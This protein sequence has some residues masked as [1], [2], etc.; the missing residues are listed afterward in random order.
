MKCEVWMYK[1]KI[2]P[3]KNFIVDDIE[4][5]LD[6][7]YKRSIDDCFQYQKY[8]GCEKVIKI[9]ITE[10]NQEFLKDNSYNYLSMQN[11]SLEETND[12]DVQLTEYK[13]TY[14][15]ILKRVPL[16][17]KTIQLHLYMDTANTFKENY[18]YELTNK[19]K[20]HRQHRDRLVGRNLTTQNL[21]TVVGTVDE[22]G[23]Y[24]AEISLGGSV[25]RQLLNYNCM[26][27]GT[28]ESLP[29][30]LE[31]KYVAGDRKFYVKYE[32]Y[33]AGTIT[34]YTTYRYYLTYQRKIDLY[35]EGISPVLYKTQSS[36]LLEDINVS[37]N[38]I[39]RNANN[40]DPD[41]YNQV[42]PVNCFCMPDVAT[43][44]KMR[45][46]NVITTSSIERAWTWITNLQNPNSQWKI[47]YPDNS[48]QIINLPAQTLDFQTYYIKLTI[49]GGVLKITY[50]LY[51]DITPIPV[52]DVYL[53]NVSINQLELISGDSI[54]KIYQT[55]TNYD[56]C[57]NESNRT[58]SPTPT[59]K[60]LDPL[61]DLDR[62][63]AKLIKIIKLPYAPFE[64]SS[65]TGIPYEWS[66][67][68]VDVSMLKLANI[69]T[70]FNRVISSDLVNPGYQLRY[71]TDYSGIGNT[72]EDDYES[73]LF[74]SDYYR[75]KFVYDSFGF[76]FQLE[77][78]DYTNADA[79]EHYLKVGYAITTTINSRF[80][81][82]FP[83]YILTRSFTDFDNVLP[84]A[85]NNEVVLYTSQYINYLRTGY[86]YDVKAKQ[87]QAIGTTVGTL[88][89]GIG[90]IAVGV[91]TQQPYLVAMGVASFGASV[92]NAVNT[93]ANNEQQLYTK[94]AQLKQ[95]AIGVE[96]SDDVDIMEAY[97]D[98][99]AYLN[100][101]ECSDRLKYAL[102]DLFYYTGYTYEAIEKPDTYSRVYFNYVQA[103][104]D[105]KPLNNVMPKYARDDLIERYKLGI[106]R[107]HSVWEGQSHG[108]YWDLDQERENWE[109]SLGRCY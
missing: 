29:I 97:S 70:K 81:F 2:F 37:W 94:Q 79:I 107:I 96:G 54:V 40:I 109:L 57:P 58:L 52:E 78:V 67:Y 99:R 24:T 59:D 77:L 88:A 22:A 60:I 103:E 3:E 8:D 33:G 12:E 38:L 87:R 25:S 49:V 89:S 73:K 20:I 4:T 19:C 47:T 50:A 39:Y 53:N 16:G 45:G 75:P 28:D 32:T 61:D 31:A 30:V 108:Q 27:S 42:N 65:S 44:I 74:H 105:M 55:D 90:A 82:Y 66:S 92:I 9:D 17:K 72:R 36:K 101:Y 64:V 100:I 68:S 11:Y 62:T 80:M 35:S 5:Y 41:S 63:D 21:T 46:E 69:N 43:T 34:I 18:E 86:N 98:N 106:T 102:A 26:A 85:R 48:T 23:V 104:I 84:I 91:G 7:C 13:M 71:L 14:W 10:A 76:D 51:Q 15:F 83:H 6:G 95:Q 93:I 1:T 56:I